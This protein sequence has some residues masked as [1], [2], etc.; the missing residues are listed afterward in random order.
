MTLLDVACGDG[1]HA[2]A[3]AAMG[4]DV[5]G[6]DSSMPQLLRS[7]RRNEASR[8]NFDILHGDMRSLP[9]DRAY[10][11]VTCLG[12]SLGYFDSDEQ[13][14]QCLQDMVD[15]LKPGGKI[16]VQV[17][18]RDYW[19]GV[20]P[21]RSWWQGRGC[22]VLDVADVHFLSGRVRIHR[23][24]VFEDGRQFEHHISIRAYSVN[25][26]GRLFNQAGARVLEI[27]G[28]RETRGRFYGAAS[29]DIWIFGQREG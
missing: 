2:T 14:R 12:S 22:L 24:V 16:A 13:N 19:M 26:L 9:R 17:F 8:F 6:L 27:S 1:R 4:L 10:D 7:A 23:T 15:V 28:G 21:C 25:E 20:L 5:T 29:Q 3:F 11:A 18:N